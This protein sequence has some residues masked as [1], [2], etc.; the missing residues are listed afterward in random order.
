VVQGGVVQTRAVTV[1]LRNGGRALLSAGVQ[2][3]DAVVAVSGTFVRD[4]DRVD[5]IR[6]AGG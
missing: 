2:P 4:G 1:A 3:G 6:Q 5:P